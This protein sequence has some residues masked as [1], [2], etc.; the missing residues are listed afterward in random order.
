MQAKNNKEILNSI[1]KILELEKNTQQAIKDAETVKY[2]NYRKEEK[3]YELILNEI[4]SEFPPYFKEN[5][6][7]SL[8]CKYECRHD[9]WDYF[10]H[11]IL[12]H[13]KTSSVW[14]FDHSNKP[15]IQKKDLVKEI[16]NDIQWH[17]K[18][19][20]INAM[21]RIEESQ[22]TIKSLEWMETK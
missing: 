18:S 20:K 12:R 17:F 7:I 16:I 21:R 3:D 15:E 8:W 22:K 10:F 5:Y 14:H 4:Y 6:Q 9:R 1:S 11:W 13:I 2:S 19:E